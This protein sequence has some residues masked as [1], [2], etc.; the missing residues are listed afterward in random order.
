MVEFPDGTLSMP[1]MRRG[2][3]LFGNQTWPDRSC[4]EEPHIFL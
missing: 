2:S 1:G 4:V 3:K